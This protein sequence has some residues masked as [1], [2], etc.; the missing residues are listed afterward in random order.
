MDVLRNLFRPPTQQQRAADLKDVM[1]GRE[2]LVTCRLPLPPGKGVRWV[3]QGHLHVFPDRIVWKGRHHP[4]MSFQRGEWLVRT[5]PTTPYLKLG[6][7]SLL[8]K[9]D[10]QKHQELRIPG[11]DMDLVRAVLSTEDT[12]P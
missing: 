12:A 7:V 2:L 5:T 6:T 11:G 3:P 8:N 10:P 4:E 9:S 1:D